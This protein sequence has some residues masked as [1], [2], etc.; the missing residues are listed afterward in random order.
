MRRVWLLGG[1]R[2]E[3][4]RTAIRLSGSKT[5]NLFAYLM[6]HPATPHPRDVLGDLLWPDFA[7]GRVRRNLSDTLY[8][9][10]QALG[11]EWLILE[12]ATVAVRIGPD[13]WVDAWEFD[14]LCAAGDPASLQQAV[15]LYP[16]DLLPE[17]Y[18]DWL[19]PQRVLL[20]EK[21]LD[22][23]LRLGRM[24]EEHNQPSAAFEHYHRLVHA[25]PL[26]EEA[27]RGLMRSL[28]RQGQLVEALDTYAR[29][30]A[31]LRSELGAPPAAETQA[32]CD[33]NVVVVAKSNGDFTSVKAAMDSITTTSSSNRYLVWVGPGVYT[34]GAT[35]QVKA[36]VHLQGAG[37]N[38]TVISSTLTSGSV[39]PDAA[40][41]Q[42]DD[43]GRISDL[44]IVNTG[45]GTFGI[46]IYSAV[47]V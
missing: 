32:L 1:L 45:T 39:G 30:E 44:S 28:A 36:Y 46:A 8:R 35:V 12:G 6:L 31:T 24:A 22:A 20:R 9:L 16:G 5:W 18:D 11:P 47:L 40:T 25:D 38:V 37:P 42:L 15:L 27:Y 4:K 29:L 14:R 33:C 19:L 41:A 21:Y 2:V 17:L 10:R 23:L 43:N 13:L 7:A 34:E 26:R 3:Q